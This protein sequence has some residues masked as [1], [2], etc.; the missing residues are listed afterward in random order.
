[1]D[2][3]FQSA[4]ISGRLRADASLVLEPEV[5]EGEELA[6]E[7]EGNAV[8]DG[9]ASGPGNTGTPSLDDVVKSIL[10]EAQTPITPAPAVPQPRP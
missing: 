1:M 3:L 10:P 9:D 6:I 5:V 8:I 7:A 4:F 2:Q